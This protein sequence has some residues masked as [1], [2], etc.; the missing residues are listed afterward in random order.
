[1]ILGLPVRLTVR[2][3]YSPVEERVVHKVPKNVHR[4]E[5]VW[6]QGA[7]AGF[8][9]YVCTKS[10][11]IVDWSWVVLNLWRGVQESQ[12]LSQ[13]PGAAFVHGNMCNQMDCIWILHTFILWQKLIGSQMISCSLSNLI[14]IFIMSTTFTFFGSDSSVFLWIVMILV[15]QS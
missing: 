2:G 4:E 6:R 15:F 3:A 12:M 5:T 13:H 9:H 11:N 14:F 8:Y 7:V 10:M 1:M